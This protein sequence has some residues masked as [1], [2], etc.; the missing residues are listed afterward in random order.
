[1]FNRA[2]SDSEQIYF[3]QLPGGGFVAI[4]ATPI[5]ALLG[6]RRYRGEVVVERRAERDRREGHVPPVVAIVTAPSVASVFHDL[7]P[8]AQSNCALAT[9]FLLRAG[10]SR[11]LHH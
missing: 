4:E 3:R 8:I 6:A 1:M 5:R 7:F 9:E 11:H 2:L 10:P